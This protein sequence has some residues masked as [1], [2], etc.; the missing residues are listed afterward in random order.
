MKNSYG[1]AHAL[2][3][4]GIIVVAL[5]AVIAIMVFKPD[6]NNLKDTTSSYFPR[7]IQ[8]NASPT[9]VPS[10]NLEGELNSETLTDPSNDF[11]DVDK[12]INTL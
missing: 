5:V 4:V 12:D 9:V 7:D 3:L 11:E 2:V 1:M 10:S 6:L 8:T